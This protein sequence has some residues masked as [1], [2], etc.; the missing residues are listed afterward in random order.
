M[1]RL[2]IDPAPLPP[3][4]PQDFLPDRSLLARLLDYAARNGGGTKVEIGQETGIPTGESTG[5][6]DPMIHYARGMGLI[7]AARERGRWQLHLTG[8]GEVVYSEDRYLDEALTLW[9]LH[10]LLCRRIGPSSPATGIADPWFALF[11]EGGVRLGNPFERSAY[12]AF[13][14]ER[15][16]QKGYLRPLSGLVPRS[17]IESSCLAATNA[18]SIAGPDVYRRHPAS[19]LRTYFP[20]YTSA[21]FLAWD[22][23]FPQDQQVGLDQLYRESGLLNVLGWNPA[24]AEPWVAW[25][26]N[27]GFLQLDRLTG[28]GIAL[29]LCE[30]GVVLRRLYDELA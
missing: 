16:G 9:V 2:E 12:L 7:S 14:T 27:R 23:L 22:A 30:T 29:R 13:L 4:F 26:V 25:M 28:G 10:L 18:L 17:Y 3:N 21:L 5:K 8:L 20:A 15:H 24:Q 6:V 19:S 11:A 1:P